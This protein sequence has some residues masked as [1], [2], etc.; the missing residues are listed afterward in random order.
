MKDGYKVKNK[1]LMSTFQKPDSSLA[2]IPELV[3]CWSLSNPIQPLHALAIINGLRA[4]SSL[5]TSIRAHIH[6]CV[7]FFFYTLTFRDLIFLVYHRCLKKHQW[8][9]YFRGWWENGEAN[10][11]LFALDWTE[12]VFNSLSIWG[13]QVND[14]QNV[15]FFGEE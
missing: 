10:T 2:F 4:E 14:Y 15:L 13:L 8:K 6:D 1:W 12:Q 9:F 7:L 3:L 5:H 11:K